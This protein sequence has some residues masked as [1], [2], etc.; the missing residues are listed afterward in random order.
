MIG[1]ITR[2]VVVFYTVVLLNDVSGAL[3]GSLAGGVVIKCLK[4]SGR[5]IM[6]FSTIAAS[7][8]AGF[9]V[10]SA[11]LTC[12]Q[13]D[14]VGVTHPYPSQTTL[15]SEL[16]ISGFGIFDHP[17][18]YSVKNECNEDCNCIERYYFPTCVGIQDQITGE[19]KGKTYFS[20]CHAGCNESVAMPPNEEFPD[21]YDLVCFSLFFPVFISFSI[22]TAPAP[23]QKKLASS[24]RATKKKKKKKNATRVTFRC[25]SS[26]F[27]RFSSSF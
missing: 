22:S 16:G 25:S 6:I 1:Q 14:L 19:I 26:A 3:L 21:G 23:V 17:A 11:F 8:A 10:W 20:P 9:Y 24:K 7:L 15:T 4:L 12:G 2:K 13:P 27:L 18:N 5:G